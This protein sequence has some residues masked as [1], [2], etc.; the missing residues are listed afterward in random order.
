MTSSFRYNDLPVELKW[1]VLEHCFTNGG[2]PPQIHIRPLSV[3]KTYSYRLCDEYFD[4]FYNCIIPSELTIYPDPS[5]HQLF[6]SKD[7]LHDAVPIFANQNRVE[8]QMNSYRTLIGGSLENHI[9]QRILKDILWHARDITITHTLLARDNHLDVQRL[10]PLLSPSRLREC[11]LVIEKPR[12]WFRN[13]PDLRT[14][15]V[16]HLIN[17]A[18]RRNNDLQLLIE[19]EINAL[20]DDKQ[21]P[22]GLL[23]L[24]S[25]QYA[26]S[27]V[28][29]HREELIPLLRTQGF[30]GSAWFQIDIVACRQSNSQIPLMPTSYVWIYFLTRSLC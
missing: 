25:G 9:V 27:E 11:N 15:I 4:T 8:I 22:K 28:T 14:T 5:F 21:L 2:G 13:H 7:F 18:F 29:W 16:G 19:K 1:K 24:L 6:V 17:F 12:F 20:R 23:D 30:A 26:P 3:R 10:T